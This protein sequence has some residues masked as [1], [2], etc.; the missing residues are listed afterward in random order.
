M[1]LGPLAFAAT[2]AIVALTTLIGPQPGQA[3]QGGEINRLQ[4]LVGAWNVEVNL[5][6][7]QVKFPALLTFT[8]DGIVLGDEPPSPFETTA[9]GNWVATSPREAAFTFLALI[10]GGPDGQ[11]SETL[12]IVG[13]LEYDSRADTWSGPFR[14]QGFDSDGNEIFGYPGTFTGTRIAVETLD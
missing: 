11:L 3:Q 5:E 14:I 10:G 4:K 8:S 6:L 1:K 9:H 7:F 2:I 12:K 13:K